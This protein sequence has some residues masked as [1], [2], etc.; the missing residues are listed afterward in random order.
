M[1]RLSRREEE[2]LAQIGRGLR[3]KAIAQ[4]LGI[5]EFTVRK[6]RANMMRKLGLR[7]A[8]ALIAHAVEIARGAAPQEP[9]F[10]PERVQPAPAA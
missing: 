8:V 6:H 9:S 1:S 4:A 3:G 10:F 5:S 7:S 2:I